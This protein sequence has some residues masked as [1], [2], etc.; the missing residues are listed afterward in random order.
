MEGSRGIG[1]VGAHDDELVAPEPRH[2]VLGP[3][4]C[5]EAIRHRR[6]HLI[7]GGMTVRVVDPLE[8]IEI[9]EVDGNRSGSAIGAKQ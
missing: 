6:E 9:D 2:G 4:C 5:G 3:D 7:S 1:D 8:P